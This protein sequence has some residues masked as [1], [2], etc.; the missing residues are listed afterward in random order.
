[1]S[2][3]AWRNTLLSKCSGA[4][5][6]WGLQK[7]GNIDAAKEPERTTQHAGLYAAACKKVAKEAKVPVLDLWT[8]FQVRHV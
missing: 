2:Y 5:S 8:A 4:L 3:N 1:M 6:G 7:H